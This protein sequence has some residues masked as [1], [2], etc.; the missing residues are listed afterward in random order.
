[1][2]LR[3]ILLLAFAFLLFNAVSAQTTVGLKGGYTSAWEYYNTDLPDDAQI[4]VN[5]T[6]ISGMVYQRVGK[7][8]QLGIEPG[9]VRRGAACVPGWQPIFRGDTKFFLHYAEAPVM[10]AYDTKVWKERIQIT[11]KVGYG[12]SYLVK[13]M[14]EITP[15]PIAD[16][17]PLPRTSISKGRNGALNAFDHG[18]YSGI[19]VGVKLGP[20]RLFYETDFYFGLRNAEKW[21]TSKNRSLNYCLGYA[22]EI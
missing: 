14:Q 16:N 1:M 12:L 2:T 20:G 8:F 11:A 22:I 17:D 7:H 13:G 4:T 15:L 6:N 9:Y 18:A 21:N 5:G 3:N 19:N 10:F